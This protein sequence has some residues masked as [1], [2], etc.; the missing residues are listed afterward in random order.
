MLEVRSPVVLSLPLTLLPLLPLC[1][2]EAAAG[3]TAHVL[4]FLLPVASYVSHQLS[5]KKMSM[6]AGTT[7]AASFNQVASLDIVTSVKS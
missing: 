2:R 1:L 4:H 3:L 5:G 6:S 7:R